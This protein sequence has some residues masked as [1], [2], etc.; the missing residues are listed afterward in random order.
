MRVFWL[1]VAEMGMIQ[2]GDSCCTPPK[3]IPGWLAEG[4][5]GTGLPGVV[6]CE[7]TM[8]EVSDGI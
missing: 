7:K 2:S 4:P 5:V 3:D 6:L 1:V 8:L